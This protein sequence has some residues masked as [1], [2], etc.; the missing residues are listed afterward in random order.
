MLDAWNFTNEDDY[1]DA[2]N[3][4]L[5]QGFRETPSWQEL[6]V[7]HPLLDEKTGMLFTNNTQ[8]L[9]RLEEWKIIDKG[10]YTY[11][12][13]FAIHST[14][15][16]HNTVYELVVAGFQNV[17]IIENNWNKTDSDFNDVPSLIYFDLPET[18]RFAHHR[19]PLESQPEVEP[20]FWN[21]NVYAPVI[22]RFPTR[23]E[24]QLRIN[25]LT[26]APALAAIHAER[27]TTCYSI[28]YQ[29]WTDHN[30]PVGEFTRVKYCPTCG[31]FVHDC[32]CEK[33][34]V[35]F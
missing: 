19:I 2:R 24:W 18:G 4:L 1:N 29:F 15:Y 34:P 6:G 12:G 26:D 9:N 17:R 21:L 32:K 22:E 14:G 25:A 13:G 3:E 33:D 30:Y 31:Y 16:A 28:R 27:S 11:E 7:D 5:S 10:V 23:E 8:V 20:M 35:P